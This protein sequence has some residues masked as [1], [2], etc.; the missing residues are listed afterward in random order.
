MRYLRAAAALL[1]LLV[2]LA[3]IPAV[4]AATVG[5]PLTAWPDL[6][7]GDLSD[8]VVIA[9]LAGVAYL[10]WAQFALAVL[11]ELAVGLARVKVPVRL[12]VVF[13]GQRQLAHVLVA[14]A[15]LL[16]PGAAVAAPAHPGTAVPAQVVAAAPAVFTTSAHA[17]A[18]AA[19]HGDRRAV[20][21]QAPASTSYTI[22]DDGPGTYWDLAEHFLGDGTRWQEIWHLNSGRHQSDGQVMSSPGLLRVGWTVLVPVDGPG[23]HPAADGH[24][25]GEQVQVQRG[26]TLSGIAADHDVA[27]WH[28]LWQTNQGRTEPGNRRLTDPDLIL[29]GW[30]IDVPGQAANAAAPT[31]A[32]HA[33]TDT[34]A[35]HKAPA[36]HA[37]AP[38]TPAPA[39]PAGVPVPTSAAATPPAAGTAPATAAATHAPTVREHPLGEETP[40]APTGSAPAAS[41][42]PASATA[43][44]TVAGEEVDGAGAGMSV[45]AASVFGVGGLLLAGVSAQALRR[46]RRRQL[47]HRRPGRAI[48]AIPPRLS[49]T[50]RA[51]LSSAGVSDVRWLSQALRGL[52]HLQAGDP[53]GHLPDV[54]AARLGG[55]DLELVLTGPHDGPVPGVWTVTGP[56]GDRWRLERGAP[57]GFDPAVADRHLAPYPTLA[58]VGY[59]TDGDYWLLD[60]ERVGA[61]A[62][63]GDGDRCADLAR[64]IGAELAHNTWSEQL[65][66]SLVGFGRELVD[67]NPDRVQALDDPGAAIA[68]VAAQLRSVGDGL[69][70]AGVDVLDGRLRDVAADLWFPHVALLAGPVPDAQL[71]SLLSGLA[72][73]RGRA[74]VAVV[75]AG[76]DAAAAGSRWQLHVDGDG[77]LQIPA[78]GLDLL[79]Q[80]L[81]AHE[82]ELLAQLLAVAART[83]DRPMPDAVGEDRWAAYADLAGAPRTALLTSADTDPGQASAPARHGGDG[84][85]GPVR[86]DRILPLPAAAYLDT[87]A[88][89]DADLQALAPAV[90]D[91]VRRQVADADPTLD[92]DLVAWA[93]PDCPRP[94]L[95]LLGPVMVTTAGG[96]LPTEGTRRAWTNEVIAYL[97]CHPR[98]VSAEQLGADLWPGDRDIATKSKIRQAVYMA[99]K[100][101]G[102]DPVTGQD[103][104]PP[105]ANPTGTASLYRA[106]GLLVDADLFRRLRLRGVACGADGITDLRAALDLVEGPPF[107]DRR[108]GGYAWLADDP[109]DHVYT[110]MIV[111]VAHVVATHHLAT[112]RPDLAAVAAGVA[113]T[114]GSSD[115]VA[116]LDLVAAGDAQGNRAE[117]DR[118]VAVILANHDA[119]V[120]EDLPPR[121]AQVLHRRRWLDQAS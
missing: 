8:R 62:L 47:R 120:E 50:Q 94:K 108:P 93:D 80:Q 48:A 5:N 59:T 67:L 44:A 17:A 25:G 97:A 114:A 21:P 27:D 72:D 118:L 34:P 76:Q 92:E 98:G 69:E 29:P 106:Q 115:D 99:R 42:Q 12:P 88:T 51:L 20:P 15:F 39:A 37:P 112:G 55:N 19:E 11:V 61:L 85:C 52:V 13:S 23:R 101:L 117:A 10:A 81:P 30:T 16:S 6:V 49:G 65:Q 36:P 83:Q 24:T 57:T 78:L 82:G 40:T 26:D 46:H 41:A 86:A 111:D 58:S 113:V 79:A 22:G 35:P 38:T 53:D 33:A 102:S 56:A 45:L 43:P 1:A 87:A 119:E 107:A 73:R 84:A 116:L 66:V 71:A 75:L 121:T 2:L 89:T 14:A 9:V 64:F 3:G 31:P 105:A 103:Y 110:G 74:A 7:A 70:A 90:S 54:V 77:R 60:L 32:R 63:T 18:A 28:R 91:E 4:L 100:R 68:A 104:V 95:R 109:L 96:D